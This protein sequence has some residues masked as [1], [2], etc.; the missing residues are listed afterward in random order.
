MFL[1]FLAVV[2]STNAPQDRLSEYGSCVAGTA[3][4]FKAGDL[5][6]DSAETILNAA[7]LSSRR[8]RLAFVEAVNTFT[9]DRHP[10][11]G[12]GSRAKVAALF[13]KMQE[14]KLEADVGRQLGLGAN[15]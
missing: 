12:P 5:S 3:T 15:K 8:E 9:Q 1:M 6:G 10:D 11:L 2:A 14:D 4:E 7:E 13:V